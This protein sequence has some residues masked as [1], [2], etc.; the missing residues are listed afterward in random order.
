MQ[1]EICSFTSITPPVFDG[2]NYEIWV[3]QMEAY[4]DANDLWEAVEE[5]YEILPLPNNPTVA[6]MKNHKERKLRKSKA[7]SILF[8]AVSPLIFNRIMTKKT[9]KEI[10]DFLRQE[11]EGSERIKGMQV[12]NLVREFEMQRMKESETIKDYS[13]KLL[14]IANKV[15]LLGADFSDSRIVQKILVTI[16]EKFEATITSL[17]NTRNMSTIT[18]AELLQA[19]QAQEQRRLMRQESSVEG[20]LLAKTQNNHGGK[21]KKNKSGNSSNNSVSTSGG[22]KKSQDFPPCPHCKKTNHPQKKCWW[23][24][25]VKCNKCGQLGHM[26][27]ICKSQQQQQ[28]EA[29]AAIEQPQEEQLFAVSCFAITSSTESWLIDSGCTSHM[30]YDQEL[31]RDLDTTFISKVR[32]GNGACIA[33]KGKGTVA[34]EGYTG[35]KLI[36]DVLYVPEIN[37]NLLSVG[38]L[39]EK[40]YKVLFEDKN[41]TIKD[42]EGRE[43]FKIQM[44][45]KSF[46]L[47]LIEEEQAAVH[48]EENCTVL[49]HKRLGHFHHDALLYMKRNNLVEG[50]PDLED[51]LPVCAACQYG[52]QTRLPFPKNNVWRASHKLQ[53]VHTDVGGPQKTP[54]LNGRSNKELTD[55]FKEGMK[56]AFE[57]TDLGRMSFFLG[58]QVQQ[59][60]NEIFVSQTKYAKEILKKF[61]MEDCKPTA[62]PMNQKEKFSKEDGAE[63]A[64]EGLYRSLIGCLMYLTATR[65]DI[66]HAV[67][68]LSRYMHCASEI[69]FQAAKRILRYVKGTVDY[70]IRFHQVKNFKL[71]GYSDSDWA[72]SLDDMKSTSGYIFSF[73]SGV[74]SWC[75]KKQEVIAQSTAEAEYI[76]AV[77]A[78][79]QALW[80]R[81]LMVDLRIEQKESTQ[82]FVD[83]Q[84]AISIANN[85][86]FHGK[87][88]HFKIKFYFLR[89][90]Q[91]QGEVKLIH[92]KTENQLADFLTKSLPKARFEILKQKL[93]I[94]SLKVKEEC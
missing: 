30:T 31:F 21:Y 90:V 70:G 7:R 27:R 82:I 84:A 28:S 16:P 10:W 14:S 41:C 42:V 20:A 53:L 45:G 48:K 89:E 2:T 64:D 54:S 18:L 13:D 38:Q 43:L 94:C 1:S 9:V 19:L 24:P 15:R 67:S 55:K 25:D 92:C 77:S 78:A 17:E 56:D 39:L 73:G 86:V 51:E 12:L 36:S 26:E 46:A 76:A 79:N 52:K 3:V 5:D 58:M 40:G 23:R 93:G 71:H 22:R 81:K 80:L 85:P 49:W 91:K 32:V 62:T 37:Q 88:K 83:S 60:Q 63:R 29:K 47:N 61:K 65:P 66:M 69:H 35:L 8:T 87:T 33:V 44:K 72:G 4:L 11:Y 68:L 59:N 57:M 75:S 74:F 6:Q 34:I 50:L